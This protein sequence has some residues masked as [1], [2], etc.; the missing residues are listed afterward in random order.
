MQVIEWNGIPLTGISHDEVSRIISNQIA[1]EIEVVI[2]T[3]INLLMAQNQFGVYNLGPTP[4][5][6]HLMYGQG[7]GPTPGPNTVPASGQRQ[8]PGPGPGPTQ[9]IYP[10][11]GN[12]YF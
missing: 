5:Q 9:A 11:N 10:H 2:R 12:Y 3:D 8:G 6:S 1:D 4:V 7:H